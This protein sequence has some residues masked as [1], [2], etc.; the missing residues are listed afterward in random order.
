MMRIWSLEGSSPDKWVVKHR[1]SM[2]DTFGRDILFRIERQRSWYFDY[3]ILYFHLAR[4]IVILVDRIADKVLSFS[5]STGKLSEIRIDREPC[6][7]YY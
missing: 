5:I 6:L 2:T 7:A 1:L 4:E 3:D